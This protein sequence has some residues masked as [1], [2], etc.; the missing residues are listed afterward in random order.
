[1]LV[2]D[3][4]PS[5]STL[6]YNTRCSPR[7]HFFL[8][9]HPTGFLTTPPSSDPR[10]MG[11]LT[12]R[13][14]FLEHPWGEWGRGLV[15]SSNPQEA[16]VARS[17]D[18]VEFAGEWCEQSEHAGSTA[19]RKFSPLDEV[20]VLVTSRVMGTYQEGRDWRRSNEREDCLAQTLSRIT[21][22]G[23]DFKK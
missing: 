19:R 8:E 10:L 2:L 15:W 5:D 13:G 4:Q 21:M 18:G 3:V 7:G 23:G 20:G 9:E 17:G 22:H 14:G 1:M 16:V 6:L 11:K 12:S